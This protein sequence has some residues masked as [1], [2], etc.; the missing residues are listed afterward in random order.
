MGSLVNLQTLGV[1]SVGPYYCP[2]ATMRLLCFLSRSAGLCDLRTEKAENLHR[3]HGGLGAGTEGQALSIYS[4]IEVDGTDATDGDF[5]LLLITTPSLFSSFS[6]KKEKNTVRTV[7]R[8][9]KPLCMCELPADGAFF[10][11]VHDRPG[12]PE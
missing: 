2:K 3:Q 10:M 12:P 5:S 4:R 9:D 7:R 8:G 11:T 1:G 6:S